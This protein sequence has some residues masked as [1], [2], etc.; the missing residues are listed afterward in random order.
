MS[1]QQSLFPAMIAVHCFFGRCSEVMHHPDPQ[2][3][4]DLMEQHYEGEHRA[5][6]ARLGY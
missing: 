4:H 1:A 5:D 6:I 2:V 3:A